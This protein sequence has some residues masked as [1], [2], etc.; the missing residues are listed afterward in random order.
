M[1][2]EIDHSVGQGF[3]PRSVS[4]RFPFPVLLPLSFLF[5]EART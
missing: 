4:L 5:L 3:L 2:D 1:L